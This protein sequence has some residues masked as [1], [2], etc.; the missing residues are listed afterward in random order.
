[1]KDLTQMT[2]SAG[3]TAALRQDL[4]AAFRICHQMGWSE[5]VGNHF[6][7]AVSEHEFLLNPCWQ[8]F[9]SIRP[10][11]L[12]RIDAR[13]GRVIEGEGT[14]DAS[15]W[16]VH[17]TLHRKKPEARVILHAHSP[18]ATALACLKD[19]TI[20]PIAQA[21]PNALTAAMAEIAQGGNCGEHAMVAYDYLRTTAKGETLT[22]ARVDGFDHAF[23][24]MG[25]IDSEGDADLARGSGQENSLVTQFEGHGSSFVFRRACRR[26]REFLRR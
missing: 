5:S 18:Y 7:A 6:S 20:V 13:D 2:G 9:A 1:M 21:N 25:N 14:P 24:I 10:Q 26:R 22:Q 17:G 16:C 4:S 23:V 3:E 19:P 12:L 8:H 15:A 11:D